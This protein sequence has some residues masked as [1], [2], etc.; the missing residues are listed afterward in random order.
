MNNIILGPLRVIP[1]ARNK[2]FVGR[3]SYLDCLVTKFYTENKHD[4]CLCAAL[5]GL[6]GVG[7]TNIALELAYCLQ[8]KSA[9]Y[10]VFWV[11]ASDAISFENSYRDIGR[12][13][14]IPGFEDEKS[15][16]KQLVYN[17]INETRSPWLMIIDNADNSD[18]LLLADK[19]NDQRALREYLPTSYN[20]AILFTTRD[21][22]AATKFAGANVITIKEMNRQESTE[23]LTKSIQTQNHSILSDKASITE[24]L[25]LLLDLPL[26]I[27]QAAAY[28]NENSTPIFR[29]L[30]FYKL[31]Q[32]LLTN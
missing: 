8:E 11:Q 19:K 31:Y 22:K 28:I 18:V 25:N 4:G 29:Y 14:K 16:V 23:L 13:F 12:K 9:D 20:G 2:D 27:K 15:D 5:S 32:N 30:S 26:A 7:K 10:S 3:Q 1:F 21:H 17:V 6:G 24:L